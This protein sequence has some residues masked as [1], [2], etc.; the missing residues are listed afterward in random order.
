[1][2][3]IDVIR[4]DY[5]RR[6]GCAEYITVKRVLRWENICYL[7]SQPELCRFV[8]LQGKLMVTYGYNAKGKFSSGL[9]WTK[10][11]GYTKNPEPSVSNNGDDNKKYYYIIMNRY[12][13][14]II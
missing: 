13:N 4:L 14:T 11:A 10:E 3:T 7:A 8:V 2:I 12:N 1:M 9:Q 5:P 6:I